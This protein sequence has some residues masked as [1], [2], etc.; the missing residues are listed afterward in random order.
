MLPNLDRFVQVLA[1]SVFLFSSTAIGK[2]A[3]ATQE[4]GM[5]SANAQSA[6]Q[7]KEERRFTFEQ[8]YRGKDNA[9]KEFGSARSDHATIA[10]EIGQCYHEKI[11]DPI[12]W[13]P[14]IRAILLFELDEHLG[15]VCKPWS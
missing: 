7:T 9:L 2:Q 13:S 15:R 5:N 1:V 3:I 11:G 8:F 14:S 12:R 4:T 6:G 10:L